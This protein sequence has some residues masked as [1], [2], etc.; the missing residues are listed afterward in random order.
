MFTAVRIRL[1]AYVVGVLALMLLATGALVY[2]LLSRQLDAALDMALRSAS[3]RIGGVVTTV[4]LPPDGAPIPPANGGHA[5]PT[6]TR[7]GAAGA[8]G[9]APTLVVG[10]GGQPPVSGETSYTGSVSM[11]TGF[12]AT[13]P[14]PVPNST[15]DDTFALSIDANRGALTQY[16]EVPSGLPDL[17]AI[18]AAGSGREDLRTVELDGHRYRLLT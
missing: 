4:S 6:E 3:S 14:P 18:E 10:T 2:V 13:L 17:D 11:S 9:A 7:V 16:G 8:E 1:I 12:G 15:A 5:P